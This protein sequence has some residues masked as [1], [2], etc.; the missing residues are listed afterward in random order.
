[1]AL[2]RK[3]DVELEQ[4]TPAYVR[5]EPAL[6]E[7]LLRNIID[8]AVRYSPGGT[9]VRV[10][11][12]TADTGV[13][14]EVIDEGPGVPAAELRRLGQRF[15]RMSRTDVAGSGLGLSIVQRIAEIHGASVS[16]A[17]GPHSTGLQVT[18]NFPKAG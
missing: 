11:V 13:R 1:M 16:F 18:V 9:T 7:V 14:V 6:A 3:V 5:A 2:E 17:A 15:H 12:R 10:A 4:G 8:N